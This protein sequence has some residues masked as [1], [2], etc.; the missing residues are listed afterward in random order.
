MVFICIEDTTMSRSENTLFIICSRHNI[1][2]RVFVRPERRNLAHHISILIPLISPYGVQIIIDTFPFEEYRTFRIFFARSRNH[3]DNGIHRNHIFC[4]FSH[5]P[6]SPKH[7]GLPVVIYKDFCIDTARIF[8]LQ[9]G[10]SRIR[11][12]KPVFPASQFKRPLRMVGD[13]RI[14]ITVNRRV[15]VILSISLDYFT[16]SPVFL[17][18][19]R[20]EICPVETPMHEI[21]G[22]PYH[23]R[24]GRF[25]PSSISV[26]RGITIKHTI[27]FLYAGICNHIRNQSISKRI[28]HLGFHNGNYRKGLS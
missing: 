20:R 6:T 23:R 10:R 26:R 18:C 28:H 24:P 11:F 15:N 7:I 19:C 22:L 25:Q 5:M 8:C 9:Q 3:M 1:L 14:H 16:G 27:D 17:S 21:L 12:V 4:Q 13:C 2:L